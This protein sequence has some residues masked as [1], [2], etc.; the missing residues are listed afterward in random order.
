MA[1]PRLGDFGYTVSDAA[2]RRE[3]LENAESVAQY[4]ARIR[5]LPE[6]PAWA[7]A[8]GQADIHYLILTSPA[9]MEALG[10]SKNDA[11]D[12]AAYYDIDA[13]RVPW[14]DLSASSGTIREVDAR[15]KALLA[16]RTARYGS[17]ICSLAFTRELRKTAVRRLRVAKKALGIAT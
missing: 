4:D 9:W 6:L 13:D 11:A 15:A 5:D 10:C 14:L 1:R 12:V 8:D 7:L 3:V 16:A 17:A 2:R